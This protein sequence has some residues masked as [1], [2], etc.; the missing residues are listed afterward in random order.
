[1]IVGPLLRCYCLEPNLYTETPRVD[2]D[3]VTTGSAQGNRLRSDMTVRAA[4]D[5][6]EDI[7]GRPDK[8]REV[9]NSSYIHQLGF[10]K[11]V[12]TE[13]SGGA[14]LRL[15]FWPKGSQGVA[16]D[17][18]SHCARFR[19][20]IISGALTSQRHVAVTGGTHM[21]YKYR[22]NRSAGQSEV[23]ALG[24]TSVTSGTISTYQKGDSYK[25]DLDA[26]HRVTEVSPGTS[27]IS[28]WDER[29]ADAIVVKELNARPEDCHRTAGMDVQ[30]VQ[31]RI[32]QILNNI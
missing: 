8:L 29:V 23:I 15:H 1:M 17:I 30:F 16:E 24:P 25:F 9:A 11:Y 21:A 3:I 31:R 6:L 20:T 13:S 2:C 10:E 4:R 19:S 28:R 22:F 18:H 32:T 12:L 26:M 5:I 27:T 14:A 7:L